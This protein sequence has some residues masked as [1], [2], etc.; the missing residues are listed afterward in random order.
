MS[1]SIDANKPDGCVAE[2]VCY[3]N[4]LWKFGMPKSYTVSLICGDRK[5]DSVISEMEYCRGAEY[6]A[7]AALVGFCINC[8]NKIKPPSSNV[9]GNFNSLVKVKIMSEGERIWNENNTSPIKR[10]E[11]GYTTMSLWQVAKIFGPDMG[12]G[13]EMPFEPEF[14]FL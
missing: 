3:E 7:A 5:L 10:D 11:E 9:T 2:P 4:P 8:P 1:G 14:K 6:I 13:K 12:L